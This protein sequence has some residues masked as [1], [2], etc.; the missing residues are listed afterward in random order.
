M[1]LQYPYDLRTLQGIADAGYHL[2]ARCEG[3]GH[4]SALDLAELI[5]QFGP[6]FDPTARS[7]ELRAVVRCAGCGRPGP[8]VRLM[9]YVPDALPRER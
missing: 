6:D 4:F 9:S 2:V 7:A 5:A 1:A 8:T 3:C